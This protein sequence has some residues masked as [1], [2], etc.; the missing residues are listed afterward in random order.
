MRSR[1]SAFLLIAPA[2]LAGLLVSTRP[3]HAV[4]T[5][6]V[7]D[8]DG[9][10]EGFNDPTPFTPTGGNPATTLG[11]ARLIAF[12]H[13][14]FL[15][16]RCL[17]SQV[18]IKIG[19]TMDPLGGSAMAAVL[20][21]AGA[22]NTFRDFPGAPVAGTW[23]PQAL[24]NALAGHDLDPATPDI[25]AQFNSDVDGPVV[26][27]ATRWYYGVDGNPP[28]TDVDFVSV[29]LHELG[30]GLGFQ[31]FANLTTGAKLLGFDDTFLRHLECHGT[32]PS[33]FGARTNA[34]RVACSTSDPNLHWIGAST[35]TAAAALPLTGGFPGGHVQ[36]HAPSPLVLGSSVSH[37]SIAAFPNQLMEP[38]YTGPN[39]SVGLA[40]PLMEDIGW[41]LQPKNGTDIVFLLDV[42]GSTGALIPQW[43]AQIPTIAQAWKAYD[44]NARFALA[45]HADFPFSPYG[46]PGEW[47]YRVE[48]TFDPNI[49]NLTTA[50][51]LLTQKVGGDE[52]ESQYEAI[53]QVL[54]GAGRD[55]TPP[56]NYTGPGD[57]PPV[58]LGQLYPMV[59]YHFT[60][61]Q[62][63]HD[64][65]LEPNYPFAG[66]SPV[67][68]KSLVMSTLATQSSNAMFFGLTFIPAGLSVAS[69]EAQAGPP[70]RLALEAAALPTEITDGPL[71][72]LARLTGGTVYNVG[73]NDL[74]LL[75]QAIQASIVRY[76]HSAQAGDSDLDG[77]PDKSDNCPLVANPGQADADHD[78]IGDACDN[79][80]TVYNP[81]Q[82]DSHFNGIGDACQGAATACIASDT[83]LCLNHD[84]FKVEADWRTGAGLAGT[85]HAV[86]LTA[87]TGYFWFFNAANVEAVS[88]V[89]D[90]CDVNS[91]YWVFAGG[92]TNVEVT[93]RVT[94]THNGAMRTYVN[95]Q[96][97]AFLPLQDTSAF[98]TCP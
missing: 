81:D 90:G 39:H 22:T 2:C 37:F 83:A 80:P 66:S 67:A 11:E 3:A 57:I 47:G 15:W 32:A 74:S 29:V 21:Q 46:E 9:P 64:R 38:S 41:T 35:L 78:G 31:T 63:F 98:S 30:H 44:P 84:R 61:P 40:L 73:N 55:L 96:G 4:A 19:A 49:S 42:T 45:S 18:E 33:G 89:L 5:V 6:S 16:G 8:N 71:A 27:G 50:L 88:K 26:L 48:T 85:G 93:L 54:T 62:V 86:A 53:Y 43:K 70:T 14:A 87:D 24:A 59:I 58:S 95:P 51:G 25:T 72:E 65:D 77:I 28:G 10:G 17:T 20:G 23:Y 75:P 76:S 52:P 97:K 34:Q 82:R 12:Q 92:L 60:Y 69:R 7:I 13:A 68:G 79:C 36:M 56:I 91:R 94:D 1:A